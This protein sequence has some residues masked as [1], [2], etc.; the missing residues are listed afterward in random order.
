MFQIYSI[1]NKHDNNKNTYKISLCDVT[2]EDIKH[3][4]N[5]N[6][7][8]NYNE[9]IIYNNSNE[10]IIKETIQRK[11]FLACRLSIRYNNI[12]RNLLLIKDEEL[13]INYDYFKYKNTL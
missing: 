10:N 7:D 5:K 9:H 8:I 4:N 6:N 11:V 3:E 1:E 2:A 12:N 13:L